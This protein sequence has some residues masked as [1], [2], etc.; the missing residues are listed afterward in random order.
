M[1]ELTPETCSICKHGPAP[2]PNELRPRVT[3]CQSCEAPIFWGVNVKSGKRNPIDVE[4]VQGGNIRIEGYDGDGV[5]ELVYGARGS[6]PYVSH[7]STCQDA[8]G[9]RRSK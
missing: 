4:P 1:H 6:G 2:G 5:P 8:D 7:F 3:E 9:W